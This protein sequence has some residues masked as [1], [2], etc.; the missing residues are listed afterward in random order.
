MAINRT[1]FSAQDI[2]ENYSVAIKILAAKPDTSQAL[3]TPVEPNT[4][5]G[6]YN[7]AID[8]VELYVS[9]SFGSR[10]IKVL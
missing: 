2:T 8:A 1:S 9:D 10:Y 6:F 7:D 4:M 3:A 5:A